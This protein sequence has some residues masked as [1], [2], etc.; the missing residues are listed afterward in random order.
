MENVQGI[1][2][3]KGGKVIE[4]VYASL[5]KLGYKLNAEPWVL[6]AEM[7]GVPQMRRRVIIV[8]SKDEKYLPSVPE[9]LFEKCLGRR[10]TNDGQTSLSFHRY[11]VT[12]GEAFWGLPALMPVNTYFPK[13]AVIDPTYSKWCSGEISTEEFLEIRWD[14][15]KISVNTIFYDKK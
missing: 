7:Y 15:E 1:L 9:A 11:P 2:S 12:V 13:D 5:S 3:M 6:D 14:Y 4:G 10:E 8:A